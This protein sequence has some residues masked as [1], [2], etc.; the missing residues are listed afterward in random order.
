MM[1]EEST[2]IFSAVES[3]QS[4]ISDGDAPTTTPLNWEPNKM[5]AAKSP[6]RYW[7]VEN[8]KRCSEFC[9]SQI[10]V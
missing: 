7:I 4:S 1:S 5:N 9:K 8:T 10:K 2:T 3:Q 6:A